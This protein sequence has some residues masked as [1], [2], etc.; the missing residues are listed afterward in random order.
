M[1][2]FDYIQTFYVTPDAVNGALEVNLTSV[3]L[4]FKAKP[5]QRTNVSGL[6]NP[7]I[8]AWICEV[9]NDSPNPAKVLN[10][11][12]VYVGYEMINTTDNAT[13]G[14]II[15]FKDTV[16]LKAGRAYGI[17]I[18]YDDPSFDIWVN[19]QGDR[20]V[21]SAG[22]TNTPSTGSQG[23]F[24]GILY[25]STNSGEYLSL[26]DRDLKFKVNIAR[27]VTTTGNFTVVNKGYEFF[28]IGSTVGGFLGGEIVYQDTAN[29]AGT[30][31]V[32]SS[33][34]NVVGTSTTFT[35]YIPG[36]S[37]VVSQGG[38]NDVLKIKDIAN[39][40]F[41]TLDAYPAFS[42]TAI[43]Y[44]IPPVGTVYYTDYT[45]SKL[46][47][48]DSNAANATFK[49]VT[50]T[51][52]IGERTGASANVVS[53]DRYK[54]DAFTPK[55]GISNPSASDFSL[56]YALANTSNGLN[57][58]S[59]L[60]LF[61]E[62]DTLSE[63]YLLSRSQ[64]VVEI[65]LAGTSKRSAAINVAFN[66]SVSN[67]NLFTAPKINANELD[68]YVYQ[69]DINA[70][71]ATT[72]TRYGIV[73][74]DTEVEKN[75][76]ARS[77]AIFKK[78]IFADDRAAEDL[79][80]YLTA[81]RPA[82]TQ[83]GVYAKLHNSADKEAF[84]DKQWTPLQLKEN[85]DKF[86][87]ENPNDFVEYTYGLPDYPE[88]Y[89]G[90]TGQF[91]VALSNNV[92]LASVDPSANVTS[93]DLI[94]VFDPLITENHEVFVVSSSNST[95]IVVNKPISNTNIVGNMYVDR[96]K[97]KNIAWNNTANDNVARYVNSSSVEFDN[98]NSMQIKIVYY[99]EESHLIPRAEQ[100]QAI[101]VSA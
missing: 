31:A 101:G 17:V 26:S 55:F 56:T 92:I 68:F 38:V 18:K 63:S 46:Y 12:I 6:A 84:D 95:A 5:T 15:A 41:L 32:S 97:Y 82:G 58:F 42:N 99:A 78:V 28:T 8:S 47:L 54:I 94:R 23:R 70:F 91:T 10:G 75:G 34:A 33:S 13:S 87:N 59:N 4:F 44:K 37:I 35:S 27:F 49:F 43:G 67:S 93:G 98:F 79:R 2:F 76:L 3:E 7:G 9:E 65:N 66:V 89:E 48:V 20:L 72:T 39:D 36:Q 74:F 21:N 81:Y 16:A 29:L 19:K 96:L 52:I 53:I 24:D 45:Q 40:T 60:E 80:V 83:I 73:G 77:K 71:S 61:K 57:S 22:T 11:S 69:N 85:I 51:R 1:S 14:T 25:K 86:S 62:N 100:I 50:G 64:E 88:V 90:L 30:L